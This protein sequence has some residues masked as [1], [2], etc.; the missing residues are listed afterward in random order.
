MNTERHRYLLCLGVALLIIVSGCS[1]TPSG[2]Q[3]S[4]ITTTDDP[5]SDTDNPQSTSTP[6]QL[7]IILIG[8]SDIEG[9]YDISGEKS[10]TREDASDQEA[11]QL[12]A[13]GIV[14]QFERSFSSAETMEDRPATIL[15]SVTVYENEDVARDEYES[16]TSDLSSHGTTEEIT[17]LGEYPAEE[18]QFE[19]NQGMQNTLVIRRSGS[20]VYYLVTSDSSGSYP[21]FT[22]ELFQTMLRGEL[23]QNK[24]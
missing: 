19:N 1:G 2:G 9:N 24:S 5:T 12:Q 10:T 14:A 6:P 16:L 3:D 18:Y 21:E 11:T 17:M 8:L 13:D 15:S 4:N 7:S 22:R 23:S 20:M